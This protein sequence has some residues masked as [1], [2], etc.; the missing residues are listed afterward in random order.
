MS[1]VKDYCDTLSAPEAVGSVGMIE[2]RH[3]S[4][5]ARADSCTASW[6][7]LQECSSMG[8]HV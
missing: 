1:R 8:M 5:D 3:A 4:V 7:C 6:L 2:H